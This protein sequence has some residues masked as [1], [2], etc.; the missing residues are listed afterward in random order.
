MCQQHELGTSPV[1]VKTMEVFAVGWSVGYSSTT[2][3]VE[4]R[5]VCMEDSKVIFSCQGSGRIEQMIVTTN[6]SLEIQ[7]DHR[8]M[9][10]F[11]SVVPGTALEEDGMT[12]VGATPRTRVEIFIDVIVPTF[13]TIDNDRSS[14]VRLIQD[15][16]N[17]MEDLSFLSEDID[18]Y[19]VSQRRCFTKLRFIRSSGSAIV[20]E[21]DARASL[22]QIDFVLSILD[23]RTMGML[24]AKYTIRTM[25]RGQCLT[26]DIGVF[27]E[28]E[29]LDKTQSLTVIAGQVASA[30]RLMIVNDLASLIFGL[31]LDQNATLISMNE[32]DVDVARGVARI[33]ECALKFELE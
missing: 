25:E 15:Q 13:F 22:D 19:N 30:E 6:M 32:E 26:D 2:D 3:L 14:K 31:F 29:L 7:I 27:R 18:Y 10:G 28:C 33:V 4:F 1:N 11:R 12:F 24:K 23:R 16:Q 8:T 17:L 21:P 20:F 5:D 9:E